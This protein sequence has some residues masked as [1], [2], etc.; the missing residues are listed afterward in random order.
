MVEFLSLKVLSS[1]VA[2]VLS[3]Q[4]ILTYIGKHERFQN[5][6]VTILVFNLVYSW[7]TLHTNLQFCNWKIVQ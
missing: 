4:I 2:V 1:F 7:A 5:F 3:G 6:Q